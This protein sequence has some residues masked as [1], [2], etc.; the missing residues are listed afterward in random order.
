MLTRRQLYELY[1]EGPEVLVRLVEQLYEHIAATEP[2][3][4]RTL[5]LT[6]DSQF[7]VIRRLQ[8]RLQRVVGE[9][10]T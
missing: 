3:E 6:V 10:R 7:A 8:R 9:A 2:P 5:R 1:W 4:V